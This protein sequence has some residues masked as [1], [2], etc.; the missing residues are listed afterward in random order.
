[1][2][3]ALKLLSLCL[4]FLFAAVPSF[5]QDPTVVILESSDPNEA[6]PLDDFVE[7]VINYEK[8]V[9]PYEA[10]READIF[11]KKRIWRVIDTREKMNQPF[12]YPERP[13]FEILMEAAI[14]GDITVY[15]TETDKFELNELASDGLKLPIIIF[16]GLFL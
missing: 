4:V 14:N 6:R 5:A 13:F 3:L 10:L 2:K 12:S 7:P 1:M 16:D 9:L 15:S 11:W 8:R